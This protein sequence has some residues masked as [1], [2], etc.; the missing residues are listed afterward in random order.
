MAGYRVVCCTYN[1]HLA[2]GHGDGDLAGWVGPALGGSTDGGRE[3]DAGDAPDFVAVGIQEMIPLHLAL[4]GLTGTALELHDRH[5]RSA[6]QTRYSSKEQ[7]GYTLLARRSLGAIALFVY[8]REDV[9][10]R[11]ERVQSAQAGCGVFGLMG[12][13]G[14]VGVRVSL[15]EPAAEEKGEKGEGRST[16]TFVTAH[17]AAHQSQKCVERRNADWREIVQRL[18]FDV[19]G[20][21]K[22]LFDCG[23]VFFFGDLNYRISLNSPT[24]LPLDI[25]SQRISS[26]DFP[27]AS[28]SSLAYTSLLSH[29]QLSQERAAGRS[30]HHLQEGRIAFPPTYKFKLGSV[31]EYASF[32]KRVPGWTDRVLYASAA[33]K[34]VEVERYSSVRDFARSDHK[35]VAAIFALPSSAAT[36]RLPL[37]SPF[38]IDPSWRIKQL[39]GLAL[40]RS[41]GG[42]WCLIMLAG[43]GRDARLGLFNLLL[44]AVAAY[45]RRL[46]L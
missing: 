4:F 33:G 29:D 28:T 3:D 26:L 18:V 42:A 10:Q 11:V 24:P 45:Y 36:T 39:V 13:K 12:N 30:M 46:Y 32:R 40:D 37:S 20:R 22:Q 41:I 43:F 21:E 17:L 27:S 1:G 19:D 7:G 6:I 38:P 8:A 44:A 23:N 35:P 5:I 25:L 14:A 2:R 31:D 34:E 16:W 9:A 15:V